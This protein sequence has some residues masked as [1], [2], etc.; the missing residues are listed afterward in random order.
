MSAGGSSGLDGIGGYFIMSAGDGQAEGGSLNIIAGNAAAG[1]GGSV[2]IS[3]GN[4]N[5]PTSGYIYTV[6]PTVAAI[7]TLTQ[8]NN[9]SFF[10]LGV[11][12]FCTNCTATDG[13]T[14]V[15]QTWNGSVWKKQN[16][17]NG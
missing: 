6:S 12:I 14:G 17:A 5:Q 8:R 10:P 7:L 15:K 4:S 11:E 13:S 9:L 16:S 2:L 3:A 1:Q